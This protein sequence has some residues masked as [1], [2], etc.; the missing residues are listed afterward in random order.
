M[1]LGKKIVKDEWIEACSKKKAFVPIQDHA[2]ELN[3]S[4]KSNSYWYLLTLE[5]LLDTIDIFQNYRF[6]I[7]EEFED[8]SQDK[9]EVTQLIEAAGGTVILDDNF[10]EWLNCE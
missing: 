3:T 9:D 6:F 8:G 1:F 10:S 4:W 5:G 7:S 2:F